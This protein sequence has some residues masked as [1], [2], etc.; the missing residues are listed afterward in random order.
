MEG[1]SIGITA[2]SLNSKNVL[3]PIGSARKNS[4]NEKNNHQAVVVS[5]RNKP[6]GKPETSPRALSMGMGIAGTGMTSC[7]QSPRN[8]Q[9]K[10]VAAT[11]PSTA[12]ATAKQSSSKGKAPS[13]MQRAKQWSPEV[14]NAYRFQSAG[15]RDLVEYEEQY[16]TPEVWAENGFVRQLTVKSS[17]YFMYFRQMRE[18]DDKYLGKTKLYFY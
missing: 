14:E 10:P 6:A 13:K 9:G 11:A 2:V 4:L 7:D 3:P 17:G 18:C 8:S 1:L 5:S 16:P 15:F 12:N